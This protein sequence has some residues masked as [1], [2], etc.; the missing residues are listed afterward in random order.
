[1]YEEKE[2]KR[3][4]NAAAEE[5]QKTQRAMF[6]VLEREAESR[7]FKIKTA[8]GGF[9]LVAVGKAGEPMTEEEFNALDQ[10]RKDALRENGKY[11]QEKLDDAMRTLKKEE[12]AAGEQL[13]EIERYAALSVLGHLVEDIKSKYA[14]NEKLLAYSDAVRRTSWRTSRFQA[15]FGGNP[16]GAASFLKMQKQEPISPATR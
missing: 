9:S 5:L 7:G 12:K 2:Y 8:M 6:E 10:G 14:N 15:L 13:N 4:K 3:R 16:G 11:I 1:V